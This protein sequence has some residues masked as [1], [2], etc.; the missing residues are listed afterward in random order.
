VVALQGPGGALHSF[1]SA[2]RA[3]MGGG[4]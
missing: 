3:A 1:V 2:V 4:T